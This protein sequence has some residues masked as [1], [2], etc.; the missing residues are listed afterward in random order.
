MASFSSGRA[1]ATPSPSSSAAPVQ[2]LPSHPIPSH[3]NPRTAPSLSELGGAARRPGGVPLPLPANTAR[4]SDRSRVCVCARAR[5]HTCGLWVCTGHRADSRPA[6]AGAATVAPPCCRRPPPRPSPRGP[7]QHAG[8][9]GRAGGE[10]GG[11]PDSTSW[12]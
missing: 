8:E 9:E 12:Q 1:P 3:P 7:A 6:G 5:V 2:P 11:G 10:R 4:R